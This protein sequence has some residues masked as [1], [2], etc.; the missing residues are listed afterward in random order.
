MKYKK[1]IIT[2]LILP[3]LIALVFYFNTIN[4]K[5]YKLGYRQQEIRAIEKLSSQDQTIISEYPYHRQLLKLLADSR[6]QSRHL[7]DYLRV[8]NEYPDYYDEVIEAIN[9][10]KD[11]SNS[12]KAK[13]SLFKDDPYFLV[14]NVD[15]YKNYYQKHQAE[16][17]NHHDYIRRVVEMVNAG[18]DYEYYQDTKVSDLSKDVLVLTNKHYYLSNDY[19]PKD[20]ITFDGTY[21]YGGEAVRKPAYDAFMKMAQAAKNQGYYLYAQSNFRD[22]QLQKELYEQYSLEDGKIAADRYS[23]RAGFSEHQTGL[24]IDI[25]S[26]E[27]QRLEDF[28]DQKEYDWMHEHAHEYGF[29]LRYP[30]GKEEVTGYKYESWHYRYVG[31][32]AA[33]YIKE[34][35]ITFDEYYEYKV[36][37]EKNGL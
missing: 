13:V 1:I 35:Q 14:R 34:K 25:I 29:I 30:K 19:V 12:I 10:N 26:P 23:A 31:L 8:L 37:G 6:Y 9:A 28:V 32:E 15:R 22:A 36:L 3:L 21:G 17:S 4:N 16:L 20:L 33:K 11:I 27:C 2:L 5:W 24:A 7:N 18:N